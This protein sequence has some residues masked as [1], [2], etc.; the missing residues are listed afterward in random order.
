MAQDDP[1]AQ[2]RSTATPAPADPFAQYAVKP[3]GQSAAPASTPA[4]PTP[5]ADQF[6]QYR[7]GTPAPPPLG[8]GAPASIEDPNAPW[9]QK[10][11]EGVNTPLTESV[12]GWH[13][14]RPGAGG[15]ERGV[16]KFLTGLTS[17]LSLGLGALTFGE[18]SLIESAGA[19]VLRDTLM[20]GAEGLDAA[21][22]DAQIGQFGKAIKAATDAQRA[23]KPIAQAVA[24]SGMDYNRYLALNTYLHDA[25]LTA[26]SDF[27]GGNLAERAMSKAF[28]AI[29]DTTPAQAQKVAKGMEAAI[30]FG[31]AAPQVYQAA[32]MFPGVLDDWKEGNYDGANEKLTEAILSGGLGLLGIKYT[33][34][35]AGEFMPAV[36]E[37]ERLAP[38][39][40]AQKVRA[41]TAVRDGDIESAANE[42]RNVENTL[43]GELGKPEYYG[44]LFAA[45][46]KNL[47]A[48]FEGKEAI[49]ARTKAKRWV[50]AALDTG[51]ADTEKAR[52]AGNSIYQRF[53]MLD[54]ILPYD[55]AT[56]S[57]PELAP[58]P[59]EGP[60]VQGA[61]LPSPMPGEST[62]GA[63]QHPGL[64]DDLQ[65]LI[66]RGDEGLTEKGKQQLLD[67]AEAY[68]KVAQGLSP[69][70]LALVDK[71]RKVNDENWTAA[72]KAGVIHSYVDNYIQRVFGENADKAV[73]AWRNEVRSGRFDLKATQAMHRVYGSIFE[74]LMRGHELLTDDP[75]QLTGYGVESLRT[76]AANVNWFKAIRA[77][78]VRG[79]DGLPAAVLRG[80]GDTLAARNGGDPN[81]LVLPNQLQSISIAANDVKNMIASGMLERHLR[82]GA[83]RDVTPR[84]NPTNI[85]EWVQNIQK[86]IEAHEQRNPNILDQAGSRR[87][88]DETHEFL[89]DYSNRVVESLQDA[90]DK[91][92]PIP[93]NLNV[94]GW[95]QLIASK[96]VRTKTEQA[97]LDR[98]VAKFRNHAQ[99]LTGDGTRP[100]TDKDIANLLR[101]AANPAPAPVR[102]QV[103][104][105]IFAS[106]NQ[107]DLNLEQAIAQANSP[108][109]KQAMTRAANIDKKYGLDLQYKQATGIWSHGGGGTDGEPSLVSEGKGDLL[110]LRTA[111]ALRGKAENQ[112]SVLL[113][114]N[115]ATGPHVQ[116]TIHLS[117]MDTAKAVQWLRKAG[118]DGA[119]IEQHPDGSFVHIIDT[120]PRSK[121]GQERLS[122]LHE[123][124][125]QDPFDY[126]YGYGEH[127]YEHSQT[128]G[129]PGP[130]ATYDSVLREAAQRRNNESRSTRGRGIQDNPEGTKLGNYR[131]VVL[132]V[133]RPDSDELAQTRLALSERVQQLSKLNEQRPGDPDTVTRLRIAKDSLDNLDSPKVGEVRADASGHKILWLSRSAMTLLSHILNPYGRAA[134]EGVSLE[135]S[136]VPRLLGDI[137]R[138][139]TV[140]QSTL[141]KNVGSGLRQLVA[142]AARDAEG[143]PVTVIGGQGRSL[144]YLTRTARE[145]INHAWQ[146]EVSPDGTVGR[147]LYGAQWHDLDQQIP[148]AAQV[149]LTH[150]EYES[151]PVTRVVETAAKLMAGDRDTM[152]V[153]PD[154]EESW[155]RKYFAAVEERHG[156]DAFKTLTRV[157]GTAR[158][159]REEFVAH[160]KDSV[161]K[162]LQNR[163][164]VRGVQE[165]GNGAQ[166]GA[167]K[168]AFNSFI[169]EL[170]DSYGRTHTANQ[171]VPQNGSVMP[172]DLR[173]YWS[174]QA[175]QGPNGK[176]IQAADSFSARHVAQVRDAATNTKYPQ[177]KEHLRTLKDVQSGVLPKDAL[178]K[179]NDAQTPAYVWH[180]QGYVTPPKY[181]PGIHWVAKDAAGNPVFVQ[182]EIA[183]HPEY[184][185]Y[186]TNALGLDESPLT[187]NEGFGRIT[188]PLLAAG[189]EAKSVLLSLSPFHMMQEALRGV[190]LG[191]NPLKVHPVDSFTQEAIG[192]LRQAVNDAQKEASSNP[193]SPEH[194]QNLQAAQTELD[195]A[196]KLRSMAIQGAT[197][198]MDRRALSEHSEGLASHSKILAK[199]PIL[200]KTMDWYQDFLFNRYM[201]S[202][203]A[204]A[205]LKMYD[206]YAAAHPDWEP[207]AVASAA[208]EHV[209]NA[210]GGQNWRAMGRAAATQDWFRL[211]AL[212][213]DWLESEMR[214][215]A[216]TL[217]GGLGDKNF[218]RNQVLLMAAGLWGAARVL[219]MVNSGNPH[220]EAP[221]GV[222]TKDKNGQD[223]IYS[224]R[225][226]PTDILHMASDPE[227]FMKG[228]L[229]PLARMG[230]EAV[231]GQDVY[232]RKL[233]PGSLWVDLASNMAPIPAQAVASAISGNTNITNAG[234]LAKAGGLTADVYRTQAQT[235]AAKLASEKNESGLMTST[236]RSRL[237]AVSRF[238]DDLR[239]GRMTFS[240]LEDL[241]DFS[242]LP[243][244]EIKKIKDN[245]KMTAGMD[246]Q[247]ARMV[248]TV[249]RMDMADA[250]QVWELATPR[251]RT[252]MTKVMTG[253]KKRYMQK[254]Y[255]DMSPEERAKDPTFLRIRQM[256]Q[257]PAASE[258]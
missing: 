171:T 81:I 202:L 213:P 107:A 128:S 22:A 231:T 28:R 46:A 206:K 126:A 7:V 93:R 229:S 97:D 9:Y 98:Y 14:S 137:E 48:Q 111:A 176:W 4:T 45:G 1:F 144:S 85:T 60:N 251:E 68:H 247:T 243:H 53:G 197:F 183:I 96:E 240:Q 250:L 180:P 84:V 194:A 244:D 57:R 173:S 210:F 62:T 225:T 189:S 249:N 70:E 100:Y 163:G 58:V 228:R 10:L 59:N 139:Y 21:A 235:L 90:I 77:A 162:Q 108:E 222:A 192:R 29:G 102:N 146:S 156:S 164:T 253:K 75:V 114:H 92:E 159:L 204:D 65:E 30:N 109:V 31:F 230:Q 91:G 5:P 104:G 215:A 155:L 83:V 120:D 26:Q 132:S 73:G 233:S 110:D 182:G 170:I 258:Q 40:E 198:A 101:Q 103:E 113:W 239:S 221:F 112:K 158:K 6:A 76:I 105:Q 80:A 23:G 177:L 234:Q 18:G 150:N 168:E 157:I 226:M 52:Q 195:R 121:A 193:N 257:E 149:Y 35:K 214:F 184:A 63:G 191:V 94:P 86:E 212:A 236:Q 66:R 148:G 133:D 165:G 142:E 131:K 255:K 174:K 74:G 82:S 15:I 79:S 179:I 38:T 154:E 72:A 115:D 153:T 127:L 246:P 245:V 13:D 217:R 69:D 24:D 166:G 208:A 41:I 161:S 37:V 130:K 129:P 218:A 248:S 175:F 50:T 99:G 172:A 12:L 136:E 27:V 216:S 238:E 140:G 141:A 122:K 252:A 11:W 36:N 223:V 124:F 32:H 203:K 143:R 209:N 54:K 67:W 237:Q 51:V 117:G 187:K 254:A 19:S 199:I 71:F 3:A 211:F 185:P 33:L 47:A 25:D 118:V 8:G 190:M 17:P 160:E 56:A 138:R 178:Q 224:I 43:N 39:Q 169:D 186:L 123:Y 242:T 201:P 61:E 220:L 95:V 2:Y 227:G 256:W 151:D 181:L 34:A 87:A 42:A 134:L 152:G 188:K 207:R 167:G 232:G 44:N 135:P 55:A 89:T 145:E 241:K 125:A 16:E 196:R 205:A 78:G 200:G 49:E 20:G 64:P 119:T 88:L 219:N 106:S 147:H 116:Y